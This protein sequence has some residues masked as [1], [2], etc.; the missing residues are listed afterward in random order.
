MHT[1]D[2]G[3]GPPNERHREL[4][5]RDAIRRV[6]MIALGSLTLGLGWIGAPVRAHADDPS[7]AQTEPDGSR[8]M[9]V[10]CGQVSG[11]VVEAD[12]RCTA[13]GGTGFG[14]YADLACGTLAEGGSA[15][16]SGCGGQIGDPPVID[17]DSNCGG[18]VLG[19]GGVLDPDSDCG[20][21]GGGAQ[22][23]YDSACGSHN[24]VGQ[25]AGYPDP[26]EACAQ[27]NP[28][29]GRYDDASCGVSL[30]GQSPP[31]VQGDNDCGYVTNGGFGS[32]GDQDCGSGSVITI[33]H[34]D[35]ACIEPLAGDADCG[36]LHSGEGT[37]V[38]GAEPG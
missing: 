31:A 33:T 26:D 22:V 13:V 38:D 5:R 9:D 25:P 12:L 6:A 8:S 24:V 35:R 7:C 17:Q 21:G 36:L 27:S 11:A 3:E 10:G 15:G 37:Y 20:A 30:V 2:A 18:T 1:D 19:G 32:P 28:A 34:S 29:G 16:D 23:S 14:V 4:G